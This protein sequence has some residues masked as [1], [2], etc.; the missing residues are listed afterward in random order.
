MPHVAAARA[1]NASLARAWPGEARRRPERSPARLL[2]EGVLE[3]DRLV[4]V[5]ADGHRDDRHAHELAHPLDVAAGV[6]R[7]VLPA[8]HALELLGPARQR[9]VDRLAALERL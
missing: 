4:A 9:L 3:Q 2:P 1:R 7:Q 6:R 5:C 8:P